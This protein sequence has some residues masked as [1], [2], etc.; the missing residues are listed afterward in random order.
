MSSRRMSGNGALLPFVAAL[1]PNT[2]AL[3]PEMA[4]LTLFS[5]AGSH[6]VY[7]VDN[8]LL[9]PR[10]PRRRPYGTALPIRCRMRW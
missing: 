3:M 10:S 8:S 1:P 7:D 4:A 2:A 9:S 5:G 6:G